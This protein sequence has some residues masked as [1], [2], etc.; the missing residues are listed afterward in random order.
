MGTRLPQIR[1]PTLNEAG[2]IEPATLDSFA[3]LSYFEW[4]DEGQRDTLCAVPACL[5][6]SYP[7]K[8]IAVF[9]QN[10]TIKPN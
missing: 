8:R 1:V 2:D 3:A 4:F 6:R 5:H 7:K 9:L 10:L